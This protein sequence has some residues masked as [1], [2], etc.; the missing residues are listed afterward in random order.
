MEGDSWS[1]TS[2][3]EGKQRDAVAITAE[4][5]DRSCRQRRSTTSSPFLWEYSW[6]NLTQSLLEP[7]TEETGTKWSNQERRLLEVLQDSGG[8]PLS[9]L[10]ASSRRV[11]VSLREALGMFK[12]FT[13]A[14]CTSRVEKNLWPQWLR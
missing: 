5:W 6:K 8:K 11:S 2:E 14:L 4:D 12:S 9:H 13:P 1:R 7:G 10:L 3:Q